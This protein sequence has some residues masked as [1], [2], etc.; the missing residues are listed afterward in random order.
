MK[1]YEIW[2]GNEVQCQGA[3]PRLEPE[4]L[5]KFKATSFRVA[6]Y[7][8]ELTSQLDF[9]NKQMLDPHSHIENIH[10]GR[11][12]YN[13]DTNSNTWLGRYYPSREDALSSCPKRK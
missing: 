11:L 4:L 12:S 8:Y 13:P 2:I 6:C 3:S 5:A 10:F 1:E 7:I 9:I